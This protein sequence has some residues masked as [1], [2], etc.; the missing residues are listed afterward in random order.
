MAITS[1]LEAMRK[2]P[3][4]EEDLEKQLSPMLLDA[5]SSTVQSG[6]VTPP[7]PALLLSPDRIQD[8]ATSTAQLRRR[9]CEDAVIP[10]RPQRRWRKVKVGFEDDSTTGAEDTTQ[11]D[12]DELVPQPEPASMHSLRKD[13][14]QRV[15]DPLLSG[16]SSTLLLCCGQ[17]DRCRVIPVQISD[18][19]DSEAQ[20]NETQCAWNKQN[21][22]WRS[23]LPWYGVKRVVVGQVRLHTLAAD[24]N[25]DLISSRSE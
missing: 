20:W 21:A 4:E 12:E 24:H 25:P 19:A 17:E 5:C 14:L 8:D 1:T 16:S 18:S 2:T 23:W 7:R 10:K 15:L 13:Q 22:K 11:D 3:P 6:K 9:K